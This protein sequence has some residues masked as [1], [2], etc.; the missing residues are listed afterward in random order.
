MSKEACEKGVLA[1]TLEEPVREARQRE[2]FILHI[3]VSSYCGRGVLARSLHTTY[4]CV[5]ILWE[6]HASEKPVGEAC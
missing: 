2:A 4:R 3:H 1:R 6:W 5:L